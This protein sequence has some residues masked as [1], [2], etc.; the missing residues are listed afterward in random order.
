MN[1]CG[2]A[3]HGCRRPAIRIDPDGFQ[4]VSTAVDFPVVYWVRRFT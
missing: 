2:D 4:N 1:A 3:L